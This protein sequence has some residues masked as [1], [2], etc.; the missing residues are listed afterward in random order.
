MFPTK[1][2]ET[3]VTRCVQQSH[4]K[5]WTVFIM[6]PLNL[7]NF[8]SVVLLSWAGCSTSKE[9]GLIISSNQEEEE[10][11]WIPG[12]R[13]YGR[14]WINICRFADM[15][16]SALSFSWKNV[17]DSVNHKWSFEIWRS[18]FSEQ[19]SECHVMFLQFVPR[20]VKVSVSVS[21]RLYCTC[22]MVDWEIQEN[23]EAHLWQ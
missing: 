14:C 3:H 23:M 6:A 4:M 7:Y 15:R 2:Q 19:T 11:S 5:S 17:L 9:T 16:S 20:G 22:T 8:S 10:G 1:Q 21:D 12:G 13:R 18:G